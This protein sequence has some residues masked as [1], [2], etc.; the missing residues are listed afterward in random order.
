MAAGRSDHPFR[1]PIGQSA[2]RK[3]SGWPLGSVHNHRNLFDHPRRDGRHPKAGGRCFAGREGKAGQAARALPAALL[4]AMALAV[5]ILW[6]TSSELPDGHL[7]LTVL[8]VG[9]GD[10]LLFET[11][12]GRFVLIDGGSS[13]IALADSLGPLLPLTARPLDWVVVGGGRS[14]RHDGL[15]AIPE[16]IP[17]GGI[18]LAGNPQSDSLQAFLRQMEEVGRPVAAGSAGYWLDLALGAK[19]HILAAS[20]NGALLR[21]Q[22]QSYSVLL[23]LADDAGPLL[24]SAPDPAVRF[25]SA[26]M[27]ADGGYIA[28]NPQPWLTAVT[29]RSDCSQLTGEIG[30]ASHRLACC[31]RWTG[32]PC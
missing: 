14:E 9:A 11:P 28:A 7:R 24:Q 1:P 12:D 27:L 18:L 25:P 10:S 15:L 20:E 5:L 19:L 26:L 22:Y 30:E 21:L 4:S 6:R 31:R 2:R 32:G 17:V 3:L 29:H 16:R 13:Q 23:P 8:D